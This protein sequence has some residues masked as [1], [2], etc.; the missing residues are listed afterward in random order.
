MKQLIISTCCMLLIA[1][2]AKGQ[3][4]PNFRINVTGGYSYFTD[5]IPNADDASKFIKNKDFKKY[6]HQLD[7]RPNVEGNAHYLLNNGLGF[8]VKFRYLKTDI[9]QTDLLLDVGQ[10]HYGVVN[11]SEKHDIIFLAPSIMY[12]WWLEPTGKFLGTGAL[13][14]GYTYLESSGNI[15]NLSAKFDGDNIGFQ[16]DLGIDYFLT[17]HISVGFATGYFYSKIKEVR[18]NLSEDKTKLPEDEQLNLSNIKLNLSLSLH[19]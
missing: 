11:L 18:V 13:S 1:L 2:T 7:W 10:N 8:G 12:A 17:R 15:D 14:V 4:L 5:A 3:E 9:P 16:V 19:F 6:V